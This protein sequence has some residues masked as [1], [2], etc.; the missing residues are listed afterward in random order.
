MPNTYRKFLQKN[1]DFSGF[2]YRILFSYFIFRS[3]FQVRYL[4]K[5][6]PDLKNI[7]VDG[8]INVRTGLLSVRAGANVL[9]AGTSIFGK[10]RC[11]ERG[12]EV[13]NK[14]DRNCSKNDNLIENNYNLL[15]K[16][17]F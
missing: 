8:G 5:N 6:F 9:I 13:E 17:C 11:R 2:Y 1:D 3:Y 15:K 4:R 7:A 14:N 12:S 10:N 16:N